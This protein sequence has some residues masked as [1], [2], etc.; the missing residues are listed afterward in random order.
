[1][2]RV[3]GS[4]TFE[5][6]P[7]ELEEAIECDVESFV[8]AGGFDS[9]SMAGDRIELANR[10]GLATIELTVRIDREASALLALEAV[11]GIFDRMRTEYTV[12]ATD[13]GSRLEAW[14]DFTLGGIFGKALDETLV[15]MQ[16]K[17]EFEDQF[18]YLETRLDVETV[19][20]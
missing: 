14:T 20:T 10:L 9:V 19:P 12:E 7:A 4:R 16:R 8:A 3:R 6:R 17:R 13:S 5:V 1:M 2:T 18:E 11:E 15:S